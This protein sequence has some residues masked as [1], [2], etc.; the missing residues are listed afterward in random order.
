MTLEPREEM[1]DLYSLTGWFGVRRKGLMRNGF[2]PEGTYEV[3]AE[4]LP[5]ND[6]EH[7]VRSN[8]LTFSVRS[9]HGE[10]LEAETLLDEAQSEYETER[11]KGE[12]S[13]GTLRSLASTFPRSPYRPSALYL[14]QTIRYWNN[15]SLAVKQMAMILADEY[16]NT[17]MASAAVITPLTKMPR[18]D[19]KEYL[20][21]V[22]STHEGTKVAISAR[23][24]LDAIRRHG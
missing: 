17:L 16:P 9:P 20:E 15:D 3:F 19:R 10:E 24:S 7:T 12:K 11:P 22:A 13:D 5:D 14:L 8:H 2:F 23:H 6:P 21:Q 18:E 1:Y 4:V